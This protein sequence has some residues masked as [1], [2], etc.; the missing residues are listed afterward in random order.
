M[1]KIFVI[2]PFLSTPLFTSGMITASFL[3]SIA[4]LSWS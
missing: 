1:S 2:Y 4:S 3:K